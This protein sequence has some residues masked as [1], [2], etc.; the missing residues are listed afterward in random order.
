[1]SLKIPITDVIYD[2]KALFGIAKLSMQAKGCDLT[3]MFFKE[4]PADIADYELRSDVNTET[5]SDLVGLNYYVADSTFYRVGEV[6]TVYTN[7]GVVKGAVKVASKTSTEDDEIITV[8]KMYIDDV[9]FTLANND[10]LF[11]KGDE[12]LTDNVSF[13]YEIET[14]QKHRFILIKASE[15]IANNLDITDITFKKKN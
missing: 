5:V 6:L 14:N 15:E 13:V 9:D 4:L 1:M 12:I 8:E 11:V 10:K 3:Y 7:A 2:L